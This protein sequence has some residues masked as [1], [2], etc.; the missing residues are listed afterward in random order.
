MLKKH[1][2][3]TH[4]RFYTY[5]EKSQKQKTFVIEVLH[6]EIDPQ[7]IIEKLKKQEFKSNSIN[8]MKNTMKAL[9][10]SQCQ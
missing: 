7:I 4:V 1:F 8:F 3:D 2:E 5:I 9:F 10:I 6:K